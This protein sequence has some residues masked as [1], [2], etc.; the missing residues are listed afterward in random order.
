MA[1]PSAGLHTPRPTSLRP[2]STPA[3]AS[4]T[5]SSVGSTS[6]AAS[7]PSVT[8]TTVTRDLAPN[9][10]VVAKC[11]QYDD[12]D[13][14]LTLPAAAA[15]PLD[16][17]QEDLAAQEGHLGPLLDLPDPDVS[18]DSSS[19]AVVSAASD[20]EVTATADSC[21]TEVASRAD[22]TGGTDAPLPEPIS[23]A[24]SE[25]HAAGGLSPRSKR[26][27]AALAEAA[28][29]ELTSTST[30]T[31]RRLRRAAFWGKVRVAVLAT[32][33]AAVAAV[34]IALAAYLY[35]SRVSSRYHVLPPT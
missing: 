5:R 31:A 14:D 21:V 23:L 29:A 3:S 17:V 27:F 15:L 7:K 28:A 34:D 4:A 13:D 32:T 30:A 19:A 6:S 1:K 18:G 33:V 9:V 35:A 11:L 26:L 20:G 10:K 24:L 8:T 22:S 2:P 16:A 25:L 12:G